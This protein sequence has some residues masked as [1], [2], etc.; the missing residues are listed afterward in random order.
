MFHKTKNKNKKYFC[1]SCLQ[2]V[3]SE[4]VLTKHKE[5][6]LSINGKQ[7]VKLEK[8]IIDFENYFQQIQVPFKIYTDFESNLKEVE[9]YE[10]CYTKNIKIM[11][12]VVLL[13]KL[14]VLMVDLVSELL[15]LEVKMQLV[16][17]IKQFL[18]S[19]NI[20]KK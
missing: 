9:S 11:L 18:K 15:F 4:N 6:C 7:S 13:T 5:N 16:N 14:F 8:G 20:P 2:C 12:L 3:S 1:K 10:R 19:M 17:L